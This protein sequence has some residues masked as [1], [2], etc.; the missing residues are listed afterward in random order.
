MGGLCTF[1]FAQIHTE[2]FRSWAE[3]IER[4][5]P[6]EHTAS[7]P[8]HRC[9]DS[10]DAHITKLLLTVWT[11]WTCSNWRWK[12]IPKGE[13]MG[14]TRAQVPFICQPSSLISDLGSV[15]FI[16]GCQTPCLPW[17]LTE[18]TPD[19]ENKNKCL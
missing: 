2:V 8:I 5:G 15:H 14:F 16:S 19:R 1:Q 13:R 7:I 9:R 6:L 12:G 11:V 18:T 17:H 4:S 10:E 3:T